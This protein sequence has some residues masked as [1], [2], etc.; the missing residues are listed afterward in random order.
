MMKAAV[1]G[2]GA[3]GGYFAAMLADA[4]HDVTLCVRTPFETLTLDDGDET[5]EVG[6]AIV[7]EPRDLP[8]HARPADLVVVATKAQ[9]TASARPWLEVLVG[10]QT[11]VLVAQN[12]VDHAER[13]AGFALAGTIIP[14]IVYVAAERVGP[15]RIVHH[16]SS[17]LI[18]PDDAAGR[19]VARFF[20]DSALA[21]EIEPEF[22][23]AAW[24]KLL[25]NV[26]ANPVTALTLRRMDVFRDEA[27][28]ELGRGLLAEAIAAGRAS[29]AKLGDDEAGL[30]LKISAGANPGSGSSMLYDRLSGRP[31]E[32][33]YLTGAV[34][35]AGERHGVPTP[36]NRAILALLGAVDPSPI[37]RP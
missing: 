2:A 18:V 33:E 12:G 14:S 35:R 6:A 27:V 1:I 19:Q 32:H 31:L 16:Y 36:L 10:P 23:T 22:L 3:I 9:D 20:E 26:V 29:G 28:Q 37:E 5:R 21:V 30:I 15:G 25:A 11:L 17:R 4:G 34:V 7:A 24:R 8:A 13:L